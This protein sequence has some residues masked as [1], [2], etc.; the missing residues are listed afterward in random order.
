MFFQGGLKAAIL[1][2]VIQGLAMIGVSMIIIIQG[3]INIG[4]PLNVFN[5]TQERGRLDFFKYV[6]LIIHINI[7]YM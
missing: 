5:V 7:K 2:D 1:S 6:T 4:G 3:T